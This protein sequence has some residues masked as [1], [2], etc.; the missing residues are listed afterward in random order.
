MQ[1]RIGL[2]VHEK[3]KQNLHINFGRFIQ[4]MKGCPLLNT[5][6]FTI[7]LLTLLK[8]LPMLIKRP[9]ASFLVNSQTLA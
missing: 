7:K 2:T 8:K 5:L 3:L 4:Y 1:V 9:R 6:L